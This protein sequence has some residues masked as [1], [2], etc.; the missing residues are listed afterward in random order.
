MA[1][2]RRRRSY[3]RTRKSR[4]GG[5][6]AP[7]HCKRGLKACLRKGRALDPATARRCFKQFNRCRA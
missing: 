6:S 1:R 4:R 7:A 5:A 2:R 3:R